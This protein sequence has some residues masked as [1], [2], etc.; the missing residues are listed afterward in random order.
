MTTTTLTNLAVT[1]NEREQC[2]VLAEE[3]GDHETAD[4]IRLRTCTE[5]GLHD[6]IKLGDSPGRCLR[7]GQEDGANEAAA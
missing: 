3:L 6:A 4:A 5:Q 1:L 2:A 7:C